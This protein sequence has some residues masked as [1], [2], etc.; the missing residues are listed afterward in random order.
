MGI[1]YKPE[2][3][4][5]VNVFSTLKKGECRT[6][7]EKICYLRS[8]KKMTRRMLA[9]RTGVTREYIG[10]LE[11]GTRKPAA[12]LLRRVAELFAVPLEW[13]ADEEM[14]GKE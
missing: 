8:K 12:A 10:M 4:G 13:L 5:G 7:G 11:N 2:R 6:V 1:V 9:E 3:R 14:E